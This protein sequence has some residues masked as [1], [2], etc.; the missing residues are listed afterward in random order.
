MTPREELEALRRLA[1]LEAK[2]SGKPYFGNVQDAASTVPGTEMRTDTAFGDM[3]SGKRK[4]AAYRAADKVGMGNVV[5]AYD[6]L[7]HH[8]LNIPEAIG[9]LSAHGV[10][11]LIQGVAGDTDYA[12]GVQARLDA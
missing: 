12:K 1:E 7:Q 9:Q 6:A 3:I 2:A 4:P 5:G 8:L 10:N 11:A